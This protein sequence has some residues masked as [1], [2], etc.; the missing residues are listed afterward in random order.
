MLKD[1]KTG[2]DGTGT[3]STPEEIQFIRTM[4]RRGSL[5]EFDVIVGQ[6]GSTNSTHLKQIKKSLLSYFFT[7]NAI[8]KQKIAMRRSMKKPRYIQLKIFVAR[9]T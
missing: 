9:L 5:R 2:I 7:L 8:N 6:V 4:L 1:F 3:T